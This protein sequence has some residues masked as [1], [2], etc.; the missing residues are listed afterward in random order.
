MCHA[1][2][3]RASEDLL[4]TY[5]RPPMPQPYDRP[6]WT[7]QSQYGDDQ[8]ARENL[9]TVPSGYIFRRR[10]QQA[11]AATTMAPPPPP[12]AQ[13]MH[14]ISDAVKLIKQKE[15]RAKR[16]SFIDFLKKL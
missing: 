10:N 1:I 5:S 16:R 12:Q 3:Y 13:E 8:D 15:R 11:P 4:R 2:T 14:L 6:D 7:Q 9:F